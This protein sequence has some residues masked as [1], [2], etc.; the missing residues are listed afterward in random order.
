MNLASET[1]WLMMGNSLMIQVDAATSTKTIVLDPVHPMNSRVFQLLLQ[2][3]SST[4][5]RYIK[6]LKTREL[7]KIAVKAK[8]HSM[9]GSP[10]NCELKLFNS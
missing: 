9:P 8:G 7:L 6:N 1:I 4:E 10:A 5:R 2:S 3:Y